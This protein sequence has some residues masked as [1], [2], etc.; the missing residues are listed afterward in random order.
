MG[1]IKEFFHDEICRMQEGDEFI[2]DE[3]YI[4]NKLNKEGNLS[5][6]EIEQMYNEIQ[7]DINAAALPA[8][9]HSKN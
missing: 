1:A 7:S 5:D 4:I 2:M 9:M 8:W 6:E 3:E